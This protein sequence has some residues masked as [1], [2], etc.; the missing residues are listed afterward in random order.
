MRSIRLKLFYAVSLLSL[1]LLT[2]PGAYT[3]NIGNGTTVTAPPQA[4]Q[5]MNFTAPAP[6]GTFIIEP[7]V[8]FVGA[9]TSDGGAAIGTLVLN[10]A[11]VY[12]GAVGDPAI[13][14][15]NL[16]GNA[17]IIGATGSQNFSLGQFTL[18]NTGALN[19]PSGIVINTK[20][21]SN[22]LFGNIAIG[23]ATDSIAGASITVN[24]D[25]SGVIALTPNTPLFVVSAGTGTNGLP[26][27]VTSNSI[28]Y[29][30]T[31]LN[32]GGNIEIFPTFN[33]IPLPPGVGAVFTALLTVAANNPGSD[34]AT[35]VAAIS[36]LPTPAAIAAALAQLNPNVN[37]AIPRASFAGAQQFQNLWSKHMG[38]GRCIY[39]EECCIE[40]QCCWAKRTNC[41]C[42][43]EINCCNVPN[44]YEIWADG[45]GYWGRQYA[46]DGFEAYKDDIYGGMV[47]FQM[48]VTRELSV[49]F[50]AGYAWTSILQ[51]DHK[52]DGHIQTY[53]ATVYAAYDSTHVFLDAA[54][55]FDYNFYHSSRHIF[56]PGIDRQ[57][58]SNYNGKEYTALGVGGYRWYTRGCFI[59][60][61]FAGLQYSY[62]DV[63]KY[64]EHGAGDIDLHVNA[65]HY[66]FLESSVG[67]EFSR[68][69][70]TKHGAFVPEIHGIWLHDFYGDAMD[71]TAIFSSVASEAGSFKTK[72]PA[73]ARNSWDVGA[74][75]AFITCSKLAIELVY[76]YEFSSTYHANEGLI[77]LSKKF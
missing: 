30:F 61:P 73:W 9:L 38:Y 8:T 39:A 53:D 71:L 59:I 51:S 13:L 67:L 22:S 70:Q 7:G 63:S 20:V 3:A 58:I 14:N 33:P 27:T 72:G 4:N 56:F 21:I 34:I 43:A 19:L 17:N 37:G 65:Q 28:L 68:P 74:S 10:S 66:N 55:S 15:V 26:V 50:G 31:G 52:D 45:F 48:P 42:Y 11:S 1:S 54:F 29:S 75:I 46:R 25:A 18:T 32:V 47:G 64:R 23:G 57:A 2:I 24:V 60:T 62:L 41:D 36:A 35:V 40:D 6:G 44:R 49:G 16:N 5:A 69:I 76:N 77:K 12:Q